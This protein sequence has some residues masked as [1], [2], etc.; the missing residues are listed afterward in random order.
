MDTDQTPRALERAIAIVMRENA[1]GQ[2][3]AAE[4]LRTSAEGQR[5]TVQAVAGAIVTLAA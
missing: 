2:E 5:V 3:Q 1:C 4:I